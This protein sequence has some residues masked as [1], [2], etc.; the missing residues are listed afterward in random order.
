LIKNISDFYQGIILSF[1]YRRGNISCYNMPSIFSYEKAGFMLEKNGS[2]RALFT[3]SSD[4]GTQHSREV[5]HIRKEGVVDDKHFGKTP[6]RAILISSLTSYELVRREINV[7]MPVGY[8][9]ENILVDIHVYHLPVGTRLRIGTAVLEITQNC[10]LCKHLAALDKRI[11]KLLRND[12][13]IFAKTVKEGK[14]RIGDAITL[15]TA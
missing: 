4:S 15:I 12:R 1:Y 3:V 9:G 7:D 10:T 6:E 8:L 13:G 5:L 11:P 2:V 14:I